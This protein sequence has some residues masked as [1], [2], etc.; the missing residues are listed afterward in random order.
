[1]E[2]EGEKKRGGG[3]FQGSAKTNELSLDLNQQHPLYVLNILEVK[4]MHGYR[5]DMVNHVRT[6]KGLFLEQLS[7]LILVLL[8]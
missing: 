2:S 6:K 1:M 3:D 5:M 7:L 8:H 4:I